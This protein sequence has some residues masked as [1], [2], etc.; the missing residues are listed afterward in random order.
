MLAG[1]IGFGLYYLVGVIGSGAYYFATGG[2]RP[3]S[4][5]ISSGVHDSIM[6][7]LWGVIGG[8]I[9]GASLK[10]EDFLAII[11]AAG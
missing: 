8:L 9:G 1:A 3:L 6:S 2:N 7:G 4:N 11:N 10:P 5:L